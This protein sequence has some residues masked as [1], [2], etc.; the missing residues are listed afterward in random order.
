MQ[1]QDIINEEERHEAATETP[2]FLGCPSLGPKVLPSGFDGVEPSQKRSYLEKMNEVLFDRLGKIRDLAHDVRHDIIVR[3]K[4]HE[5]DNLKLLGAF[6]ELRQLVDF[7]KP[8]EV[9]KNKKVTKSIKW[10]EGFTYEI[11]RNGRKLVGVIQECGAYLE[12]ETYPYRFFATVYEGTDIVFSIT[13]CARGLYF[14]KKILKSAM[15]E[16]VKI[17][18][19]CRRLRANKKAKNGGL[20]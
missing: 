4:T 19:H 8:D 18:S 10:P 12:D 3:N 5:E 13:S 2:A 7:Y 1:D 17:L 14:Q 16:A 11:E 20:A 6:S 9:N 15:H